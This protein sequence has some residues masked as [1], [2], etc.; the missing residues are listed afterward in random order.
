MNSTAVPK[1]PIRELTEVVQRTFIHQ[2]RKVFI[3]D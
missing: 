1:L 2:E 3:L